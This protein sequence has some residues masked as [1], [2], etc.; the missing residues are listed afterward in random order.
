M[1]NEDTIVEN[2]QLSD[3]YE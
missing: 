3:E 1:V 2:F